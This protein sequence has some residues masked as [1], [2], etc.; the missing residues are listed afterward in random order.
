MSCISTNGTL[1]GSPHSL[2]LLRRR[3]MQSVA[4]SG[5]RPCRCRASVAISGHQW[6]SVAISG[7][8]PGRCS[9]R[10]EAEVPEGAPAV[11]RA[12]KAG[13][14]V[15]GVGEARRSTLRARKGRLPN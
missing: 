8:R 7:S 14:A 5:S 4:I 3:C 12:H 15:V 9:R 2:R 6:P 10:A 1:K 11:A 13:G